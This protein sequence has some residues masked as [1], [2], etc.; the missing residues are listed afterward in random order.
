MVRWFHRDIS[1]IEAE[2]VL[3]ARGVHGSFLCRPSKKNVGDFS[4]SVRVGDMI[5]HIRI[6][7]TGDYYDLYGGEKFATLAEL[8]EYYTADHGVLQDRDGTLIELK[9]PLNCSDPTTERWYHGHL[10]GPS[11]E[12]L[13]RERN[14]AG[15]FLVRESLSKPGD[16]VLS[17]MTNDQTST[18]RR[19][20]HIKIMCN[21][22]RYTVGGKE[23][24]D[25]LTDL[26]EHFK[27][28]G[29]EELSGTM[30]YLKQP[31]YSTRL[32]AA[33][34][35]SRVKQLD[36]TSEKEKAE[37]ADKKLKGGFWEE[38][39]TLQKLETKVTKSRDEGMRPEN[40]SK[41][42]YKNILPFDETRVI[43]EN[44]DP[45]VV[46]SDYI[47]ANYVTNKLMDIDQQK[48]YIACQGCLLTTVNDFW[49]MTWQEKSRVI[50]MTTREVEK[51]RNKCVPYWPTTQ[52]ETKDAGRY[53]VT[54]LSEKDATDYKVRVIE[55]SAPH[56][57]EPARTIWHYQYLSWPDHGVPQEPGGVL[58]FLQQVN[59]KQLEF[60]SYG[61]M[62]IHCS[63]GIGRT[64]TIV[65]IDMLIDVIDAKGLDCDI[66]IQKCIQMVREQRSGMVQTE[67]QYKFIYMAVLQYIDST[68]VTRKA[69]METET[70]Y[71]NLSIQPKHQK[72]SRKASAKKNEDPY[73]G[74]KGKKDVKKQNSEDKKSGSVRKR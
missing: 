18:G 21:N 24:F 31:Y 1:G 73:E 8:V 27:R 53:L 34:I 72:A 74:A 61:P 13:L 59:S 35:E 57:K 5:T 28:S 19:V 55:L 52:G 16:F 29:I 42:R 30:V 38:F 37:G 44:A 15:T 12:K 7:N 54:L 58:S 69:G 20:S 67:A 60:S 63:A 71:G 65:V 9:Y 11:A 46:G 62:I 48:V 32:N 56:R 40:K 22:D 3:K 17:A 36:L 50:V 70:E 4:L 68:K 45:N 2:N 10:S 64:G 66:D 51:G 6:Q 26:V 49:Q 14:E 39:D 33:D 47:N 25:T 23:I 41:N 43:M